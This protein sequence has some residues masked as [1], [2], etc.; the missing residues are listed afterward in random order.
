MQVLK[1][2]ARPLSPAQCKRPSGSDCGAGLIDAQAALTALQGGGA[3]GFSLS[4]PNNTLSLQLGGS[5]SLPI[6]IARSGGFTGA[7]SLSLQGAPNGVSGSFNPP[8][9]TG[10]SV[11][12][13]SV[14]ASVPEGVYP[15]LV[16]GVSGNLRASLPLTLR[17]GSGRQASVQ[18]TVVSACFITSSGCDQNRSSSVQITQAGPSAAYS[19]E[20]LSSGSYYVLG[21]KDVNNNRRVD[22]GDYIGGAIN[23]R[24]ELEPVRPGNLRVDFQLEALKIDPDG[25]W[26]EL[27]GWLERGGK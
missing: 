7:V 24:G 22:E 5:L 4:T 11:L 13:L 6:N 9:T 18:G 27:R 2:T 10:N 26:S 19:L 17:V 25:V 8:N 16:Q 23:R 15:L 21:W 14:A 12:T 20:R 3:P 1:A